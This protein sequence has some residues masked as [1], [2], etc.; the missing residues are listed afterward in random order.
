MS[1]DILRVFRGSEYKQKEAYARGLSET[2]RQK[3]RNLDVKDGSIVFDSNMN[4]IEGYEA[5]LSPGELEDLV[6]GSYS[7]PEPVK[8]WARDESYLGKVTCGLIR[9]PF[10]V[11]FELDK[12]GKVVARKEIGANFRSWIPVVQEDIIPNQNSID[13]KIKALEFGS[14][15][16]DTISPVNQVQT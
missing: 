15:L 16:L 13:G 14:R 11:R 6:P 8:A 4:L 3:V 7:G 5:T 2:I 10:V 12:K 1:P 9:G